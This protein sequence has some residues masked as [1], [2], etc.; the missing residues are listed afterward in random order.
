MGER[1]PMLELL[2]FA[3]IMTSTTNSFNEWSTVFEV[4][5]GAVIGFLST[6]FT[7]WIIKKIHIHKLIKKL[8]FEV[9]SNLR[10]LKEIQNDTLHTC[11]LISPIWNEISSSNI[12]LDIPTD[13]YIKLITIYTEVQHF[14][15]AEE[16]VQRR[17]A[18]NEPVDLEELSIR[19][20]ERRGGKECM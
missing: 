5:F 14:N 10:G 16:T 2:Q 18:Q 19:S 8:R 11:S 1:L 17:S 7:N 20:E 9:K 4:L 13:V 6:G 12:L 15:Q 3:Y